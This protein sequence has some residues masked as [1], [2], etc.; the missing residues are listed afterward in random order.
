MIELLSQPPTNEQAQPLGLRLGLSSVH[1]GVPLCSTEAGR[2]VFRP[3]VRLRGI[4]EESPHNKAE[5]D[6][7]R[8]GCKLTTWR[9]SDF[10]LVDV[11]PSDSPFVSESES[12]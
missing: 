7:K 1:L 4:Q 12:Y 10:P 8:V 3:I 2:R 5:R 6:S 11:V 9:E